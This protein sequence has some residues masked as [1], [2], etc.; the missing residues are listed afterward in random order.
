M[1]KGGEPRGRRE[2]AGVAYRGSHDLSQRGISLREEAMVFPNGRSSFR[3]WHDRCR[4]PSKRAMHID[5]IP[6]PQSC[7]DPLINS[8]ISQGFD[9]SA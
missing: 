7:Y 4:L 9:R 3:I 5:T 1:S 6:R 2:M 8:I